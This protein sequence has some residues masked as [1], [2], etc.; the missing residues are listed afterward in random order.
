MEQV[1]AAELIASIV[2]AFG[3]ARDATPASDQPLHV[4][5]EEVALPGPWSPSPARAL[6]IW[7]GWPDG[8]PR[9][10]S[11]ERVRGEG[12]APPRSSDL[13]YVLGEGWWQFSF[14]F[15]WFGDDPVIAVQKWLERFSVESN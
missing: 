9:F 13:I 10:L 2:R 3:P 15:P 1:E 11:D 14:S 4:V 12:G 5:M 7:E 8:R 6:V